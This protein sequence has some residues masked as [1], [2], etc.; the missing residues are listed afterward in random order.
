MKIVVLEPL[1]LPDAALRDTLRPLSEAGHT[2]ETWSDRPSSPAE[3]LERL[4]DA[5]IAVIA[6]MPF[7]GEVIRGAQQ[8]TFLAVAFTG[9]NHIDLEAC[10]ERSV[11]VS[12]AAGFSTES[13]A[14]LTVAMIIGLLRNVVPADA[15]LRAGDTNAGLFGREL[16]GMTVGIVGTGEIG[17]RVATVLSA[18]GVRLLGF[19]R[20]QYPEMTA[21]GLQYLPLEDVLAASDV[22]SLHVA[23]TEQTRNLISAERVAAMKPGS[24]LINLARGPVVDSAAVARALTEGRLA[25]L[26][27]DVYE[28]EPPIGDE[29][30]FR[31]A[32]NTLLL[33]HVAFGT[34]ESFH[35]RARIVAENVQS[36]IAGDQKRVVL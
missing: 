30:P 36:W 5:E 23:L 8:L 13:V 10:R 20:T 33:P 22:V 24:Y 18:F 31:S 34:R 9:V 6:N 7:P 21:L 12:N 28:T 14:E 2:I 26:A 17:R 4:G 1:G 16:N 29:H 3:T 19:N 15:A 27:T 25:G 11:A 35:K 32:P